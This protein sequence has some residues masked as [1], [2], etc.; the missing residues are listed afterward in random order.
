MEV[1]LCIYPQYADFQMGHLLF[2]LKKIGQAKITTT[3]VNGEAVESLGGLRVAADF[4]I[5]ELNAVNYDLVLLSGGDGID[6]VANDSRLLS[7][8]QKANA[9]NI[10]IG[11]MCASS[12]LLGQAGLLHGR[13]FTCNP[14]TYEA[15]KT[16]FESALYTGN[17]VET[18]ENITTA[19]GVAF[20]DFTIAVGQMIGLWHHQ[21]DID[22]AR[23]FCQGD[24]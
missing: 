14:Q 18:T 17:N 12:I 16:D 20:A 15:Y 9:A 24:A 10:P 6:K 4:A 23:A 21:Q 11:S 1:L 13:K 22:K 2:F 5:E 8:L 3:S 7:L 19:Q